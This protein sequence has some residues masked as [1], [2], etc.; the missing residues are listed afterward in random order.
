MKESVGEAMLTLMQS[1]IAGDSWG[2]IAIPLLEETTVALF[3]LIPAFLSLNLGLM[4]VVAG[5]I[6]DRQAQA[7]V[8]DEGLQCQ[9]RSEE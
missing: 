6:V 4:Y 8:D 7:R 5:V 3:V 1:I 2:L 9:I